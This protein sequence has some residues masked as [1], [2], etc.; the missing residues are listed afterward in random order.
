[1][2]EVTDSHSE[3]YIDS[4]FDIYY[5]DRGLRQEYQELIDRIQAS[6]TYT[7]ILGILHFQGKQR[8]SISKLQYLS[9]K[10]KYQLCEIYHKWSKISKGITTNIFDDFEDTLQRFHK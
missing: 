8:Y 6:D 2:Q 1:M 9:L 5:T 3:N 10:S 7:L 4:Y